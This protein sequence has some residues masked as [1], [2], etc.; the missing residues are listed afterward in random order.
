MPNITPTVE[1]SALSPT[2]ANFSAVLP[3]L[4]EN[5]VAL[6]SATSQEAIHFT[7]LSYQLSS[8]YVTHIFDHFSSSRGVGHAT[9]PLPE[10]DYGNIPVTE[11]LTQAG[12]SSFE[13]VSDAEAHTVLLSL[14]GPLSLLAKAVA[15]KSSSS[16]FAVELANV[17]RPWDEAALRSVLPSSVKTIHVLEDAPNASTQGPI[18]INIFSTLL[19][20]PNPPNVHSHWFTHSQTQNYISQKGSLNKFLDTLVPGLEDSIPVVMKKLMF[21]GTPSTALLTLPLL[22]EAA[23]STSKGISS[24][25]SVDYDVFSKHRGLIASRILLASKSALHSDDILCL[26]SFRMRHRRA[27]RSIS[28]PS[29]TRKS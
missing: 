9:L 12:Y 4:P 5:I 10:K 24:R 11:V 18:H 26:S 25:L 23:L 22:V 17:L 16:G 19:D 1:K 13:Y 2:L 21:F 29:W 27:E 14:N 15:N 8:S 20:T 3:I 7:Q 6:A 28:L